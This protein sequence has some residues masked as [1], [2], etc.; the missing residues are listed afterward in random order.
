[1]ANKII[2]YKNNNP[3]IKNNELKVYLHCSGVITQMDK[4]LGPYDYLVLNVK[5]AALLY[6][7]KR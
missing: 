1:M 2:K 5:D 3:L 4:Y 6:Y 7:V